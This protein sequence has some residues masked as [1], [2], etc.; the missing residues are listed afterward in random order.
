MLYTS[1]KT[2]QKGHIIYEPGVLDSNFYFVIQGK[3]SIKKINKNYVFLKKVFTEKFKEAA[4]ILD[5]VIQY[6]NK[7][8][9]LNKTKALEVFGHEEG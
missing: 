9:L 5:L 6:L 1:T 7:F 4:P 3:V 8:F 2:F